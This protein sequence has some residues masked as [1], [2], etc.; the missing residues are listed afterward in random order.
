VNAFNRSETKPATTL[1]SLADELCQTGD[2]RE[3]PKGIPLRPRKNV[4][5]I[6]SQC[7]IFVGAMAV[8]SL[9]SG[10]RWG[11]VLGLSVQPFWYYTS[12]RHRQWGIVAAGALYGCG[13]IL[14]IYRNFF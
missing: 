11:F 9:G 4:I 10:S 2:I 6:V 13:W 1:A 5:E 14:G 7:A 8:V 3:S 12:I